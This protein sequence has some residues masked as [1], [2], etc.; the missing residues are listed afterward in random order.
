MIFN[1]LGSG[2]PLCQLKSFNARSKNG[3]KIEVRLDIVCWSFWARFVGRFWKPF[4]ASWG[5]LSA[6]V[7][8]RTVLEPVSLRNHDFHELLRIPILSSNFMFSKQDGIPQKPK[9]SPRRVQDGLGSLLSASHV[10]A[11]ILYCF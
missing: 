9:I 1:S 11:S 10:F 7:G 3:T 5:L 8:S 2:S 4:R 6:Q